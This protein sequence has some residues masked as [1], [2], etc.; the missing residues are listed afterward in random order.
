MGRKNIDLYVQLHVSKLLDCLARWEQNSTVG[1]TGA[2]VHAAAA[3]CCNV[4]Q[5]S[6]RSIP[7]AAQD[8]AGF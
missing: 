3:A 1:M 7:Q 8:T 6:E 2:A 5:H 4:Q